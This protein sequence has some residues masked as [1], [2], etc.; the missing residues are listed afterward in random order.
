MDSTKVEPTS[1]TPSLLHSRRAALI[2]LLS[3]PLADVRML[4]QQQGHLTIPLD[5]WATVTFTLDGRVLRLT[6]AEIFNILK[7]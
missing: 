1:P 2:A 7:G 4:A 3:L 6:T 5:Q